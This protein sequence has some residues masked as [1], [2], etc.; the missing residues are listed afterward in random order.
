MGFLLTVGP[1]V[2]VFLVGVV[3]IVVLV[4]ICDWL[5]DRWGK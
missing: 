4:A 3:A 5:E 1:I 2:A